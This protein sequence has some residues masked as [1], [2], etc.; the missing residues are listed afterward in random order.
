MDSQVTMAMT[1]KV[2]KG[3]NQGQNLVK[4]LRVDTDLIA[5]NQKSIT[6]TTLRIH[7]NT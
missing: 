4:S 7:I 5:C 3:P 1:T 2:S 6:K